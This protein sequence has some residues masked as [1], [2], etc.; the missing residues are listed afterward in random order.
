MADLV[1]AV[2]ALPQPANDEQPLPPA[3]ARSWRR[4]Y[5][6]L[7][8]AIVAIMLIPLWQMRP[9]PYSVITPNGQTKTIAL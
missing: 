1:A 2:P 4:G 5:L 6:A 9:Q 8:A 7:A 3:S